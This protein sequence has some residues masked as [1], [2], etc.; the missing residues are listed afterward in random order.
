MKPIAISV[1]F[2][3]L[4]FVEE[5]L[6]KTHQIKHLGLRIFL[7]VSTFSLAFQGKIP[8]RK[9]V[10]TLQCKV[11]SILWASNIAEGFSRNRNYLPK[12]GKYIV[13]R[14]VYLAAFAHDIFFQY[15]VS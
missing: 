7:S 10:E 12:S 8:M 3:L 5:K 15:F 2:Y 13:K 6:K 11:S 4:P 9:K 1:D 14:L